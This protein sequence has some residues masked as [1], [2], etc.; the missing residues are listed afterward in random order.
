MPAVGRRQG[1]R[2]GAS[3]SLISG[4]AKR[5]RLADNGSMLGQAARIV[6]VVAVVVSIGTSLGTVL[7][8][9]ADPGWDVTLVDGRLVV[10]S[11]HP[12]GAAD[13]AGALP[14]EVVIRVDGRPSTGS[15]LEGVARG[16]FTQADL[17]TAADAET[18]AKT[19][20]LPGQV[21][22][23][24]MP[25]QGAI[26]AATVAAMA[27]AALVV[28]AALV[29]VRELN[30]EATLAGLAGAAAACG[31]LVA[32]AWATQGSAVRAACWLIAAATVGLLAWM[33]E[34]R[35]VLGRSGLR[36]L[37]GGSVA[38]M[39]ILAGAEVTGGVRAY[40]AWPIVPLP[41]VAAGAA[42][43]ISTS[44]TRGRLAAAPI[45]L[46][47]VVPALIWSGALSAGT[48]GGFNLVLFGLAGLAGAGLGWLSVR[49]RLAAA[50][51]SAAQS[52]AAVAA[53]EAER[54]RIAADIHD[55]VLQDLTAVIRHLDARGD[56]HGAA[57]VADLAGRLRAICYDLRLPLLE[58]FGAG[59][60]LEWLV[61][62]IRA[63]APGEVSLERAEA[64][65]P[66]A[67]VE[68]AVYRVA[69]EA[70]ANAMRHAVCPVNVRY[71]AND[72]RATLVVTDAGPRDD[73][74][75]GE[76]TGRQGLGLLN[77]RQR[78]ERVGASLR[79]GRTD[80]GGNEVVLTWV[81]P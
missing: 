49:S 1:R 5:R 65:R 16:Q 71:D 43:T 32:P 54:A 66:P 76:S 22:I 12:G 26:S 28:L 45:S 18:L 55:D 53:M 2:P 80:A 44:A 29:G 10:I 35:A 13:G 68:L 78:A 51:S 63:A 36:L 72:A 81:A 20:V 14:G 60:A 46:A 39:V 9:I 41:L 57:E 38:A 37:I 47:W 74:E 24:R 27:A 15:D 61:D 33:S 25:D 8:G 69:Q 64:G 52:D 6:I 73:A 50:R 21:S 56:A 3:T 58:D 75:V 11:V 79:V 19:G 62:R 77:M 67:E 23:L 48:I 17:V 31:L 40:L 30:A 34:R 7:R 4:T 59:A 70:L 42:A